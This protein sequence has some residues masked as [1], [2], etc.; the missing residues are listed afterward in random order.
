MVLPVP[1]TFED[2]SIEE[3][4]AF[5]FGILSFRNANRSR[6]CGQVKIFFVSNGFDGIVPFSQWNCLQN[7]FT[8]I[9]RSA[10][11]H[12]A[13]SAMA[14]GVLGVSVDEIDEISRRLALQQAQGPGMW[15]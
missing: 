4:T 5:K 10:R 1:A 2:S 14:I 8:I 12:P 9:P 7:Y 6:A 3:M 13:P 11:L 15:A